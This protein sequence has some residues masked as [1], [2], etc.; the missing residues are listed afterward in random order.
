MKLDTLIFVPSAVGKMILFSET[1]L[2]IQEGQTN[3]RFEKLA[4]IILL[5]VRAV[6]IW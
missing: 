6:L 4:L 2:I 5:M 1:K 3:Y